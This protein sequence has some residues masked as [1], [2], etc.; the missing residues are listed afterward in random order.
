MDE[1]AKTPKEEF[2]DTAAWAF[3]RSNYYTVSRFR[4]AL[5]K[6]TMEEAL[7]VLHKLSRDKRKRATGKD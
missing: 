7:E 6:V 5:A 3:Q 1:Q 4:E 2:A